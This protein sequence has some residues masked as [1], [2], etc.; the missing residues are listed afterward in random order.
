MGGKLLIVVQSQWTLRPKAYHESTEEEIRPLIEE[1]EASFNRR[2]EL[3]DI[4]AED[5]RD[6]VPN[7]GKNRGRLTQFKHTLFLYWSMKGILGKA[8]EHVNV[9]MATDVHK[10]QNY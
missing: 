6:L 7:P 1:W 3:M 10:F 2:A 8:L 9:S 4:E 5:L